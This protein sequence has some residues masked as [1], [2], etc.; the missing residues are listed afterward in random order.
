MPSSVSNKGVRSRFELLADRHGRELLAEHVAL[1]LGWFLDS[2]GRRQ[3]PHQY[4]RG[5]FVALGL[6]ENRHGFKA[7]TI[8]ADREREIHEILDAVEGGGRLTREEAKP[9]GPPHRAPVGPPA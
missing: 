4:R 9:I 2:Q 1:R 3:E 7:D 8:P 5:V 6:W